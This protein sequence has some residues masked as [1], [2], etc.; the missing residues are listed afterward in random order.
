MYKQG[1]WKWDIKEEMSSWLQVGLGSG[2]GDLELLSHLGI[3]RAEDGVGENG[4][5]F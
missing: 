2:K 4:C 1:S 5:I 3:Q